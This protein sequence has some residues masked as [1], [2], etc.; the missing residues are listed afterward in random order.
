MKT[1]LLNMR[2]KYPEGLIIAV[3]GADDTVVFSYWISMCNQ[4]LAYEFLVCGG[5]RQIR[6]LNNSL[7]ND[8]TGL[9]NEFRAIV[10]RDFDDLSGF[11]ET[12]LVFILD[13]YSIENYLVDAAVINKTLKSAYHCNGEIEVRARICQIFSADYEAFLASTKEL[14]RRIFYARRCNIR[15]DEFIPKSLNGFVQ[16]TLGGTCAVDHNVA[17]IIP[18]S[19]ELINISRATLDLEFDQL[20]PA[21]RFRGKFARKFLQLWIDALSDE[22]RSPVLGLFAELEPGLRIQQGELSLG[23]LA[24]RSDLPTG[25]CEF[26]T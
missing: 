6:H 19:E 24:A 4:N 17:E 18:F 11:L 22:F 2:S 9:A 1:R 10:D 20:D 14:N 21:A 25:F 8:L 3:E 13:R 5:K 12:G 16:V 7:H 23:P 15:I 26:F